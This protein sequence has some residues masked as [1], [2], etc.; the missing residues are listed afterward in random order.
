MSLPTT[1]EPAAPGR[2]RGRFR[3]ALISTAGHCK[4]ACGFCF[5]A[6]RAHGFLPLSLYTRSLSRL[7][8]VGVQEICLTG[9]E[10][11]HHPELRKLVRL[12]HQFGM[13]VSVVTSARERND[14]DQLQAVAHLLTNVTVSA[15]SARA[16][17]LGRT[18]RST[19]SGI[20]ALESLRSAPGRILH[21]TYWRLTDTE[22]HTLR[23]LVAEAQIEVQFSPVMLNDT[24]RKRTGYSLDAYLEQQRRD[25][26]LLGDHFQ[27]TARFQQHLHELRQL[28]HESRG[29]QLCRGSS[30]YV[31][32]QGTIRR[33]PYGTASVNVTA[34]RTGIR[35]FIDA[36]PCERTTPSCAAICRAEPPPGSR[37]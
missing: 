4:I 18:T 27:F 11:A 5:R 35:A 15:D 32:A 29:Q 37:R 6:D 22:C 14:V 9:G 12:A 17:E 34:P 20:S 26:A 13:P 25:T 33:C 7:K 24:D 23:D 1:T 21:V 2:V 10:P 16:M 36:A 28:H 31:S 8:E 3:S 19:T 30:L